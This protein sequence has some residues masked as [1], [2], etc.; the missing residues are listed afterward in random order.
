MEFDEQLPEWYILIGGYKMGQTYSVNVKLIRDDD[1]ALIRKMNEFIRA[2][3]ADKTRRTDFSLDAYRK[4]GIGTE[5]VEDLMKIFITDRGFE[6]DGVNFQ[7]DFD[8]CY[9]W[10]GVMLEMFK[11]IA[12]VLKDGSEIEI[13]PDEDW[14]K[15]YIKDGKV[16]DARYYQKEYFMNRLK[17]YRLEAVV[18]EEPENETDFE[19]RFLSEDEMFKISVVFDDGFTMDIMVC[20]V[21]YE[22]GGSNTCFSQAVLY[23]QDGTKV[24]WTASEHHFKGIWSLQYEG[25]TYEVNI[26]PE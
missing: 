4:K 2:T 9:G 18:N 6:S 15:L 23:D 21:Q 17:L 13:W 8:A 14:Q 5:S 3:E 24:A 7:S 16:L 12:P 20:G 10:E 1:E 26:L 19:E 22:D 25:V 11:F